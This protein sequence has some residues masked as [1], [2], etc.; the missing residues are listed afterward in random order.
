[1]TIGILP[2][3]LLIESWDSSVDVATDYGLDGRGS[4]PDR[5]KMFFFS[6]ASRPTLGLTQPPIQ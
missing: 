4:I 3:L 5:D 1:M 2:S 6:I